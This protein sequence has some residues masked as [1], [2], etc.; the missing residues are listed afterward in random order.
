LIKNKKV[1]AVIPA[2][3]GSKGIP[4][5]N[6]VPLL[7]KPLINWTIEAAKSS[8]YIDRLI[9][10]SDDPRICAVAEAA[11]CDVP[12]LRPAELATDEAQTVDVIIDA[13]DRVPGFELVVVLQPT[14]PL[15][16]SADIDKCL[17]LLVDCRAKTAVSVTPVEE[18]P[19][20]MYSL[21]ADARLD[22]FIKVGSARSLRRQEL[23]PAFTLNGA[24]YV[25]EIGWLR[26]SKLFV[27]PDAV[28]YVMPR[29]ISIDIDEQSD[30]GRAAEYLSSLG[31][32]HQ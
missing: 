13:L 12:F 21:G 5:K 9:L 30:L 16:A 4:N 17:E 18:H 26:E 22:S 2:R 27:S 24:I 15:R 10:S 8:R 14:S 28:G 20:L 25:A 11:G 1:L 23:P 29:A 6:I 31:S 32:S 3:G 19:F 7:G